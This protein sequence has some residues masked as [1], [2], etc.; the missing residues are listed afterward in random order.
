MRWLLL[1]SLAACDSSHG[2][3]TALS[4]SLC[5]GG[6]QD[7]C[8]GLLDWKDGECCIN[9][10]ATCAAGNQADCNA[11]PDARWTGALCCF[12]FAETCVG[13][14]RAACDATPGWWTGSFCCFYGSY[15]CVATKESDCRDYWTGAVCCK[16]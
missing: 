3:V 8:Q 9:A 15:T 5:V 10:P 4:G 13:G 12:H 11:S 16:L 1:L 14:E 7:Q 6:T 2:P